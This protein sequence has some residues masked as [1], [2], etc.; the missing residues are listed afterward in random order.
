MDYI[1]AGVDRIDEKISDLE[2]ALKISMDSDELCPK[3]LL[4]M[5]GS[6]SHLIKSL[7]KL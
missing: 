6:S 3:R 2:K 4:C 1:A 7:R 5:K